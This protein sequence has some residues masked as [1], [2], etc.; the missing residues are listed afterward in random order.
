[1]WREQRAEDI[2]KKKYGEV[3]K[4]FEILFEVHGFN[5]INLKSEIK[6]FFKIDST[7][8]FW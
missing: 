3:P 2:L 7:A 5:R 6:E 8:K 1:M 4:F